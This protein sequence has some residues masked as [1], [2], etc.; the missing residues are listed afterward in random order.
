[1]IITTK[2][3]M[4]YEDNTVEIVNNDVE[5]TSIQDAMK[6]LNRARRAQANDPGLAARTVQIDF[7][8][9]TVDPDGCPFVEIDWS[10]IARADFW[11]DAPAQEAALEP[12]Q[13]V[14]EFYWDYEDCGPEG[15]IK[16]VYVDGLDIPE[17]QE[18]MQDCGLAAARR[19]V[20]KACKAAGKIFKE[21]TDDCM[22]S[23]YARDRIIW[24]NEY[25]RG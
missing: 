12:Q 14:V 5:Y 18:I 19:F 6:D 17:I 22:A 21:V 15:M 8:D 20:K 9:W 25:Q 16:S 13:D 10:A 7:V 11:N 24:W 2:I 1:M 23:D 4:T 3:Q